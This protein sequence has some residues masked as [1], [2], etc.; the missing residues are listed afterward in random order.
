MVKKNTGMQGHLTEHI[1]PAFLFR[2]PKFI[3]L[4]HC[5]NL[6]LLQRNQ[7]TSAF[8]H[9]IASALPAGSVVIDAGC[10]DGQHLLPCWHTF[11]ELHF[12]GV[13]KNRDHI[14]FGKK[15]CE[16]FPQKAPIRFFQQN[17]E[18]LQ[19]SNE[20]DMILCIGILQYIEEDS[21][22]IKNFHK[23]LKTNG[24]L[25]VYTP[26][27]GRIILP[28][29]RYFFNRVQHYEKTQQRR[30]VYTAKEITEKIRTAGFS[31]QQ[32]KF[33]YGPLGIFG[34][35]VYSLLLMGM[36]SSGIWSWIFSGLLLILLPFI[37]A[38]I[39]TDRLVPKKN[40]NGMI[41]VAE[42]MPL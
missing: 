27:N 39:W 16:S 10:G 5:W 3:R 8:I 9:K 37:V 41:I 42:K 15:Y 21:L 30:R 11:P 24:I 29:Y 6:I 25:I 18:E 7:V 38:I 17:L 35:E 20:A 33:T 31:V 1:Y 34:H 32:K 23:A 22:V 2:Y 12:R 13:D 4:L 40:G 26:V 36:G 28:V 14:Y 19:F